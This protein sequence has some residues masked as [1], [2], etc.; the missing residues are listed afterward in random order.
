MGSPDHSWVSK[1]QYIS[2]FNVGIYAVSVIGHSPKYCIGVE[3]LW[4][5]LQIW[6]YNYKDLKKILLPQILFL[7]CFF[8]LYLLYYSNDMVDYPDKSG[9]AKATYWWSHFSGPGC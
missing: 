5:G 1:W 2:N 6:E 7:S 9:F 8:F 3:E 4:C